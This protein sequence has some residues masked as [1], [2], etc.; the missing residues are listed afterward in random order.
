MASICLGLNVLMSG[1]NYN[2]HFIIYLAWSLQY[3]VYFLGHE[4]RLERPPLLKDY[5]I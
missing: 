4:R 1:K 5:L 2:K 3:H